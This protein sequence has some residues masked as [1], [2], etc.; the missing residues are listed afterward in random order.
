MRLKYLSLSLFSLSLTACSS[1]VIKTNSL[2]SNLDTTQ[3]ATQALNAIYETPNFDYSGKIK[4]DLNQNKQ[5]I[6][7]QNE[8]QQPRLDPEIEKKLNQYLVT[9][10]IKL[11]ETEKQ[12]LYQQM[13]Q[14]NVIALSEIMGKGA[15]FVETM[16]NDLNIHYDGTVNYRQKMASFNLITQYKK[17]NLSVE[18]RIPTIIDFNNYKFYT[19]IFS[20]MP[21]LASPEDQ[22]KYV[23]F[24]F[25]KY[26]D[27]ISSVDQKALL[28]YLKQSSV[29]TY[30]VADQ[31]DLR[32]LNVNGTE[33]Q[34]GVVE[35][36]R[37]QGNV[38][39][40]FLKANLYSAI[41]REYLMQSVFKM[42]AASEQSAIKNL[43][44][45]VVSDELEDTAL[46]K[47]DDHNEDDE[48][49]AA[50][51]KLYKAVNKTFLNHN[52]EAEALA[53]A[54]TASAVAD[55]TDATSQLADHVDDEDDSVHEASSA[56]KVLLTSAQCESL[57]QRKANI[58]MGDVVYCQSY[59]DIDVLD[60]AATSSLTE[61]QNSARIQAL[62]EKFKTFGRKDYLVDAQQ[63]KQLW[64]A[65]QDEIEAALP[66]KNKRNPFVIDLYIDQ[67]GR[68]VKMDYDLKYHMAD[69]QRQFNVKFDMQI[70]NY[71][72]ATQ[73]DRQTL[74]QAKP[75]A[76][77]FKDG[78]ISRI[79]GGLSEQTPD[80]AKQGIDFSQQLTQLAKTAYQQTQSYEKTYQIIF[81]AKL[82]HDYPEIVKQYTTQDLQEIAAVYA[83]AYTDEDIYNPKGQALKYIQLLKKK[84]HLE[85]DDQF[86]HDLGNDVDDLVEG[87]WTTRQGSL[88]TEN[89]LKK[90]K[91]VEAAFAYEYMQKF[92][93]EN[94]ID[95]T[96]RQEFKKT[97][98]ILAKAYTAFRSQKFNQAIVAN[99]TENSVEFIDYALFKNTYEKFSQ[100]NLK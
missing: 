51:Y 72:K 76:E 32:Q 84:H 8:K 69:L 94:T 36:I 54:E 10:K 91:T 98:H 28:E 41:N 78:F 49:T 43:A 19:H 40:L 48:A 9:Q 59:Y 65:H 31:N 90:H 30:L 64:L 38:E 85:E 26:K 74:K 79:F 7:N 88:E 15:A 77:I 66:I 75:F 42:D 1:H 29:S 2:H 55:A 70:Q 100:A 4:I 13:A 27:Q 99:L 87:V 37:L 56:E 92:E 47:D 67:Y 14:P 33:R 63:F 46:N 35:K 5:G 52:D 82:T 18:M 80:S 53:I 68:M 97:A 6:L 95:D 22:D 39:E 96:Q 58:R 89:L 11:S 83:Y 73:I 25:S 45:Q 44:A 61:L 62:T 60:T 57:A 12:A 24:D 23:Y 71:G 86:D 34:Q 20:L 93:A 17:P 50:M 81:I 21:Y 3:R 16:L